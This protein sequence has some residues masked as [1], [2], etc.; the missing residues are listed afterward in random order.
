M[1]RI[2]HAYFK[3]FIVMGTLF[4]TIPQTLT[5]Q[6]FQSDTL[7]V[8]QVYSPPVIEGDPTDNCWD[9]AAWEPLNQVWIP[10]GGTMDS[11]D[12]HGRYK[13]LW[14]SAENLLYV[15][16][17]ITDDVYVDGYVY[18]SV[19]GSG[20]NYPDYDVLEVFIDENASKGKH[21]FDATGQTGIDWGYNGENALS[22]H[23]MA[24]EP[25]E[26]EAVTT[27][28]VCDIAGVSW[29]DYWIPNYKTHLPEFALAKL[30]GKYY[31]EFS[32]KVY[33]ENL[34]P[35]NPSENNLVSLSSGKIM[36][37]SFAY[38][39]NDEAGTQRDNFIGS[40][41]VPEE[42]YNDHWMNA[43]DF[44]A[45]RL[46]GKAIPTGNATGTEPL[47]Y[48][49]YDPVS[50]KV[51]FTAISTSGQLSVF[52]IHGTLVDRISWPSGS[53]NRVYDLSFEYLPNGI[54]L[55]TFSSGERRSVSKICVY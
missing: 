18:S 9:S 25:D 50:R 51:E 27:I 44:R 43:D 21:V 33:D 36:G 19:P 11:A 4:A 52:N 54:Y 14:S 39:D 2:Y 55:F 10:W 41:W 48:T 29:A 34:D 30:A 3:V 46:Q 5:G 13:V 16:A 8:N 37:L 53:Q 38:C 45:A 20:N 28:D 42:H 7:W 15:L 12:F 35:G 17:E 47:S 23:I 31:W 24:N 40:V 22:Y 32:C 1:K 6:P 49:V 26:G